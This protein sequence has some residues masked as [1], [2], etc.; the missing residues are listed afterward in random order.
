MLVF[1]Y[2]ALFVQVMDPETNTA[3]RV[4][5][6]IEYDPGSWYPDDVVTALHWQRREYTGDDDGLLRANGCGDEG[7]ENGLV[8]LYGD[9]PTGTVSVTVGEPD[10]YQGPYRFPYRDTA[11]INA[12]GTTLWR[13]RP[14]ALKPM[15]AVRR[16]RRRGGH[17]RTF[18][19]RG[20]TSLA[21]GRAIRSAGEVRARG[22]LEGSS[23][24]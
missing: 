5:R 1:D 2:G 21:V 13:T 16:P 19:P 6:P 14:G 11:V 10:D 20:G 12:G 8:L 24:C 17:G 9:I 22:W 4:Q 7:C 15:S 23:G 3:S 18:D